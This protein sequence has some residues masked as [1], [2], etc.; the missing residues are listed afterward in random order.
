MSHRG[1]QGVD[2]TDCS[3]AFLYFLCS[4][5]IRTNLLKF[6]GFSPPCG[7]A[8]AGGLFPMPDLKTN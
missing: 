4:I 6:L 1:L 2:A 7:A 5:S 8:V 3:M